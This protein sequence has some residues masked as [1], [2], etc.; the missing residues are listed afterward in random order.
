M[1][2]CIELVIGKNINT[3]VTED[4]YFTTVVMQC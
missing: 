1:K 4:L 2:K 3:A